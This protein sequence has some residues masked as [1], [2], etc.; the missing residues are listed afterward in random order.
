MRKTPLQLLALTGLLVAT[1]CSSGGTPVE[2]PTHVFRCPITRTEAVVD[3]YHG[4]EIADPY[5][6]LEDQDGEATAAWVKTQSA[7]TEAFLATL[8]TREAARSRLAELWNHERFT[9]PTKNGD[10]WIYR[11]NDGLQNQ[12]VI[13]RTKSLDQEGEVLLDPN[14]L[15]EDGSVLQLE[16]TF[17]DPEYLVGSVTESGELLLNPGYVMEDWD[18]DP[19]SAR[20][21]LSLD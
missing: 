17:E 4:T 5:R 6:W 19:T 3:D 12:S 1:G 16:Y 2:T 20:R 21:H 18:C 7:A 14:T 10:W 15:S 11:K 13:Y 9:T 8:P